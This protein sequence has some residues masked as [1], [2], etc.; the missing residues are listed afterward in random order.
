LGLRKTAWA[1]VLLIASIGVGLGGNAAR[2]DRDCMARER[3]PFKCRTKYEPPALLA[4]W[5][6]RAGAAIERHFG[7]DAGLVR[8]L[9]IA[10]TKDLDPQVRDRY[11]D[12]G[13]VHMLSISGLH[14]AIVSGAMLLLLQAAR[15]P[16]AAARWAG[17]AG[18]ALCPDD[19][20]ARGAQRGDD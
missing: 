19:R 20:R 2:I 11:A 8:A 1:A 3:L 13:I 7:E 5:R 17:L 14:V 18:P 12:A 10:D 9:L 4:P 6:D 15:M 16:A